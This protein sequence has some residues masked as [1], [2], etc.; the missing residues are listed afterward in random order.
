[1]KGDRE[2]S[3]EA[4]MNDHV[5]K[6]I[7]VDRLFNVLSQWIKTGIQPLSHSLDVKYKNGNEGVCP[8]LP[9]LDIGSALNRLGGNTRLF[10]KLLLDFKSENTSVVADI[11]GYLAK[12]DVQ[13]AQ[14]LAHTLKG[15]A[16]NIGAMELFE[17]VKAINKIYHQ[18]V[19]L[20]RLIKP[21]TRQNMKGV[22]GL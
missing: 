3:L 17:S 10:K 8:Q 9:G 4:G 22:I 6:P 20:R 5:A 15:V 13:Q 16:G 18:L 21:Y 1:M 11:W 12:G 7:D 14:L 2:A 19:L